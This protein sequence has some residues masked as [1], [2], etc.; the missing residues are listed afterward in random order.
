MLGAEVSFECTFFDGVAFTVAFN[1]VGVHRTVI[2]KVKRF[3][4]STY[5][6]ARRASMCIPVAAFVVRP[7]CVVDHEVLACELE[8]V[9]FAELYALLAKVGED[10]LPI[11][12]RLRSCC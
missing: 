10:W 8:R 1:H 3:Q 4:A 7:Q 6:G 5:D 9:L 2:P 11:G 12:L